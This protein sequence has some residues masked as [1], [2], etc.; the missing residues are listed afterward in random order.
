MC[1]CFPRFRQDQQ[2]LAHLVEQELQK[3]SLKL[4]QLSHHHHHH[5]ADTQHNDDRPHEG[6]KIFEHKKRNINMQL[7][8]N[9]Q[10]P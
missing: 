1:G 5:P 9:A 2:G 4:D 10:V 7:L 6:L 3:V 8:V